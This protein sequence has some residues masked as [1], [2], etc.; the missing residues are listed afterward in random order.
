MFYMRRKLVG[1][2]E[3]G[4]KEAVKSFEDAQV[5]LWLLS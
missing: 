2:N 3:A 4:W 1:I 5:M